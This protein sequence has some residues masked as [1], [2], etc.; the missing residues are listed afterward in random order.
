MFINTITQVF[1]VGSTTNLGERFRHYIKKH[2]GANLRSI[3]QDIR[4]IGISVFQMRIYLIPKE[5]QELRLLIALEQYY[6]LALNPGNNDI[7]VA[8]G[9][10]GGM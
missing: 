8:G 4:D 10:P 7:L 1:Y 5:L 9:S 6:I 3:L 2:N